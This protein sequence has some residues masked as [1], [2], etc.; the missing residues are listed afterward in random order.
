MTYNNARETFPGTLI[1]GS[2]APAQLFEIQAAAE[3]EAVK[4]AF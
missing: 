3:R 1:A 2:F 4:V